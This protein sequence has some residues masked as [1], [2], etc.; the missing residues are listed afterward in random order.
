M[1][2]ATLEARASGRAFDPVDDR[3][4]DLARR[5]TGDGGRSSRSKNS[6]AGSTRKDGYQRVVD[7]VSF[8]VAPG[9]TLGLVGES[10]CGKTRHARSP[11]MGLLPRPAG[12]VESGRVLLD[13][14]DLVATF[15]PTQMREVR[16]RRIAMIFQE[17]MTA[18]NPV[19]TVGRQVGRDLAALRAEVPTEASAAHAAPS[20]CSSKSAFPAPD[21]TAR[22]LSA[23]ALGRHAPAR[24][25][26]DGACGPTRR[27]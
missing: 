8:A 15:T 23:P 7:R 27:S 4:R 12:V 26:R 21:A 13:G 2:G 20:S 22:G 3:R 25:D 16:G 17:P 14:H 19:H 18:L 9:E 10:G 6:A 24:D 1:K 11:I 5:L